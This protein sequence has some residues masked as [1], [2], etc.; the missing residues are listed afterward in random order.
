M[1]EGVFRWKN[2]TTPYTP[3][4]SGMLLLF[5]RPGHPL[6]PARL[7]LFLFAWVQHITSGGLPS[8][9][10]LDHAVLVQVGPD[11]FDQA[12]TDLLMRH[13]A[14]TETQRDL[15]LVAFTQNLIRLRNLML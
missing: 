3:F 9:E 2:L 6:P 13:L 12:H 7:N 15:G 1:V 5:H 11:A 14:T 8:S 10:L 4:L